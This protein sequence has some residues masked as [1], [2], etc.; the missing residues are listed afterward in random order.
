[1]KFK[2]TSKNVIPGKPGIHPAFGGI[3]PW[4]D[5]QQEYKAYSKP[6]DFQIPSIF[7][8]IAGSISIRFGQGRLN[9]SSGHF[10]VASIP[11]LLP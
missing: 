11:I 1:M 6:R 5:G 2:A 7:F 10:F 4:P 3:R 9:P 8:L